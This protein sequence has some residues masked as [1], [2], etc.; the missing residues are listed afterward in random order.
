M[1]FCD[2]ELTPIDFRTFEK[3]GP[4]TEGLFGDMFKNIAKCAALKICQ[5]QSCKKHLVCFLHTVYGTITEI[6]RDYANHE[7]MKCS[8]STAPNDLQ[9]G[10]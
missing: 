8:P 1:E 7:L 3:N 2:E 6:C 4:T 9:W 10:E 5:V